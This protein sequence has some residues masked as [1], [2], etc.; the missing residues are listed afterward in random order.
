MAETDQNQDLGLSDIQWSQSAY[1]VGSGLCMGTADVVPGV[2]GGTMAVALGIY[3]RLLAAI[4]SVNV[5]SL[6]SLVKLDFRGTS[7]ILHWRFLLSLLLGIGLG[8]VFMLKVVNLPRLI[9]EQPKHVY[10]V[11]FGLVLGSTIVLTRRVPNWEWPRMA[12]VLVGTALGFAI[13]NLVPVDTP[14]SPAFIFLCGLL[15]ICAMLLPGISG[16]FVLLILGKYEYIMSSL[17]ALLHFDLRQLL[18]IV[19]FLLGCLVGISA[20]ARFLGWLLQ[21]WHDT[22]LAG[23]IGLL[24]GSLWRIWPYQDVQRILVREKWRI[25]RAQPFWPDNVEVG[26]VTLLICGLLAVIVVEY[27]AYRR[28]ETAI[29]SA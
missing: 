2:S 27:L 12:M 10:A 20:F 1:I 8:I 4:A 25:V 24:I 9:D 18:V 15:A 26:V 17:S 28:R 14:D 16:S 23:L 21:R 7:R 6:R 13:V 22:V 5:Q 19:P 11:F 29:E 3:Q